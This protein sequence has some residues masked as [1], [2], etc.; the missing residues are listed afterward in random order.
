MKRC[1]K[2]KNIIRIISGLAVILACYAGISHSQPGNLS[3]YESN[4]GCTTI[5]VGKF[6]AADSSVMIG[7]NEDMGD[8]SGI[9]THQPGK[10]HNSPDLKT[11]YVTIPQVPATYEYWA[12]GNSQPVADKYYDGGWILCGMNENGLALC[13]NS[14]F[15]R[16][17]RIPRGK[18][19]LRYS[20]RRLILERSETA[21]EAVKLIAHLIDT[22][23]LSDEPVTFCVADPDESWI[24]E[25]TF[26]HWVAKRT[27][28]NSFQVIANQYTIES[29]WDMASDDLIDYAVTQGWYEPGNKP[30]NF[31]YIYG[32]LHNRL[33]SPGNTS[34]EYQGV[35]MLGKKIGSITLNDIKSVLSLPPVQSS[36]TQSFA[37]WH[38]NDTLPS[39][40]GNIMWFGM[41]GANT[42]IAVPVL[43][44][45]KKIPEEFTFAPIS[46]DAHSAWWQFKKFQRLIYPDR[47]KYADSYS[48]ARIKLNDFQQTVINDFKTVQLQAL[49]LYKKDKSVEAEQLLTNFTCEKLERSLQFIKD[50]IVYVSQ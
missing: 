15:T 6:A 12:T 45:C 11:N 30:F 7:H 18:G 26:R 32:K 3:I 49:S 16:E 40:L 42:S 37:L 22:Y 4:N 48:D 8:R 39:G 38:L 47:W 46:E 24:V 17:K 29:D 23:G 35:S 36:A 13:C 1:N 14:V 50:M 44:G 34:R 10:K 9:L 33:D 5:L 19:I 27:P 25:T 43:A 31:K 41:N 21:V 2:P 20:I 28:D